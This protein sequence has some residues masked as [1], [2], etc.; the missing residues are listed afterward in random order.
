MYTCM[1]LVHPWRI[2]TFYLGNGDQTQAIRLGSRSLYSMNLT[3]FL[4]FSLAFLLPFF[5]L[6]QSLSFPS[7]NKLLLLLS[8]FIYLLFAA[9]CARYNQRLITSVHSR[10]WPIVHIGTGHKVIK[11]I[12]VISLESSRAEIQTPEI[13]KSVY[14]SI[15]QPSP[16]S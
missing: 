7:R 16:T 2:L 1:H 5:F 9:L 3:R 8:W 4:E 12:R 15:P 11:Y 13:H 10:H 14:P 6:K